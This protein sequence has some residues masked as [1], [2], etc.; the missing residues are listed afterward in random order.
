MAQEKVFERQL[1]VWAHRGSHG[2]E[3]EPEKVEHSVSIADLRAPEFCL[4]IAWSAP[5]PPLVLST[6]VLYWPVS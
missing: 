4:A 1:L 6:L 5:T 2:C 3:Q